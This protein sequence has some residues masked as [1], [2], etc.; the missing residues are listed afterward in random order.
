MRPDSP[1]HRDAG[2]LCGLHDSIKALET[3]VDG[4]VHILPSE[5]LRGRPK[6]ADFLGTCSYLPTSR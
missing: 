6:D 5:E 4:A 2:G 1:S 3:L